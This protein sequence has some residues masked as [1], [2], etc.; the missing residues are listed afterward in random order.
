MM[1]RFFG[2]SICCRYM[3]IHVNKVP[4]LSSFYPALDFVCDVSKVE[5]ED[6]D[7]W[8]AVDTMEYMKE[9]GLQVRP[10]F[11]SP[12]EQEAF[13]QEL[14]EGPFR[15]L[16]WEEGHWDAVVSNYRETERA[17]WRHHD[18]SSVVS[19]MKS[20]FVPSWRWRPLHVLDMKPHCE[21]KPHV[22]A[23]SVVG[24]V[25]C[26][27]SLKSPA[28]M[29]FAPAEGN[30]GDCAVR[31]LLEPGTL[32]I[33][34]GES[35]HRYT[36]AIQE[37][38]QMFGGKKVKRDRRISVMLRDYAPGTDFGAPYEQQNANKKA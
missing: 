16:R 13:F 23:L 31:V 17:S 3:S 25:V 15:R 29:R 9:I 32:Y 2:V 7:P 34:A 27:L 1:R 18:A 14:E 11:A 10:G 33:M 4:H 26:G 37:Q 35:R 8:S 5:V 21:L 19:R 24:E 6:D 12:A 20:L 22:D 30:S 36:H 38:H 28:V